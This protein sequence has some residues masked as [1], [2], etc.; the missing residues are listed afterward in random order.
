M[1]SMKIFL[2]LD[3][4]SRD[5]RL[6]FVTYMRDRLIFTR[7]KNETVST[8]INTP[9]DSNNFLGERPEE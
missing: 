7:R 1:W 8:L 9:E 6:N 2:S 4:K 3:K 5:R